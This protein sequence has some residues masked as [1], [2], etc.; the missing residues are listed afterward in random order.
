MGRIIAIANQKGGVGKTTSAV[1]LSAALAAAEKKI[2]LVDIDPQANSTSG[3]GFTPDSS[4]R[5]IY[6]A[7]LLEAPVEELILDTDL[8]FLKLLPSEKDLIGAEVEL[9]SLEGREFILKTILEGV[10]DRFDYIIIDCPPS[11]GILT[12]NALAAASS[13]LIP[14]QCEYYALEGL[15]ELMRTL[16]RVKEGLNPDL[17]IEGILFTMYDE[18]TN[19]SQ[20]V[21]EEVKNHFPGKIFQTI[22]PRNVRLGEAPSFGKPIILYDLKSKGAMAY[23]NLAKEL[24]ENEKESVRKRA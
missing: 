2:L 15:S 13:L 8:N 14:L 7:L 6:N 9:L 19:L 1:N 10:K 3:L 20:Q 12:I 23:L 21:M 11:L 24:I 5:S 18:R 4:Q 22:V 16:D 17:R